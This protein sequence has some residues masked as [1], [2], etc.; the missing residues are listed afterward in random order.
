MQHCVPWLYRLPV[1]H[2][3]ILR[4]GR[5]TTVQLPA[6]WFRACPMLLYGAHGLNK[7]TDPREEDWNVPTAVVVRLG[8]FTF[9]AVPNPRT[10]LHL[11]LTSWPRGLTLQLAQLL[12]CVGNTNILSLLKTVVHFE[13]LTPEVNSCWWAVNTLR[14]YECLGRYSVMIPAE[15]PAVLTSHNIS[16]MFNILALCPFRYL[17]IC[18]YTF[19][20]FDYLKVLPQC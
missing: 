6:S 2:V 20:L 1:W 11:A 5:E 15:L 17:P 18:T 4:S 13:K 16:A 12:K 7:P 14:L 3:S 10:T 9:V 19:A 8:F